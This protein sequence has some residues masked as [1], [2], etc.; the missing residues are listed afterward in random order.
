MADTPE[1][2]AAVLDLHAAAANGRDLDALAGWFAS[3][4]RNQIPAHPALA[5]HVARN[6]EQIF[7]FVP[8]LTATAL[9]SARD[10]CVTGPRRQMTGARRDGT[11]VP[12]AG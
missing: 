3:G 2:A 10:A 12:M 9:R 11:A 6:S 5:G 8:G 7:I 4:D 1:T